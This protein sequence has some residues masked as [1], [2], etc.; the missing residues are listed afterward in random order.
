LKNL[1]KQSRAGKPLKIV[2]AALLFL[3]LAS[4]TQLSR[5]E[6]L[7]A[8][9]LLSFVQFTDWPNNA[10]VEVP[11]VIGILGQPE[12][13]NSMMR[14]TA[15]KLVH[16]RPIQVRGIRHPGD[17]KLCNVVYLGSLSGNKL[18]EHLL[19]S[20]DTPVLT[21][22][23]GDRFHKS[24]GIIQLLI[25]D[26]R[27]SFSV[28]LGRLGNTKLNISSKLLRLGYT[29]KSQSEGSEGWSSKP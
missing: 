5:E 8:A 4:A 3:V 17:Q 21:I 7:K 19:V 24:G 20:K 14:L 28:H 29:V 27:L 22:G 6:D 25:E 15:G 9:L 11:I 26:G 18:E 13:Y 10:G 23:E 1:Q 16:G 12:L 2:A